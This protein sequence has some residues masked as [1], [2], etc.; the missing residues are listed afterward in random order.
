MASLQKL[1]TIL[2]EVQEAC[3]QLGLQA[4]TGVFDSTDETAQL[5]GSIAN[6]AGIMV[7]DAYNWEALQESWSITGDGLRT[8]WD[9]PEDMGYIIDN[10]GWA[11]FIRRPV[12]VLNA[13]QWAAISS[14]LSQSFY[15]NPACRIYRNKLQF[16]SPPP[17]N[18][19][20]VFQYRSKNWVLDGDDLSKTL[21]K[22]VKNSD[23][24]RFDWLLMVLAIKVKWLEQKQMNTVAA[25]SDFNDR[26]QQL[27]QKDLVAPVLTLSGP[28]PGG[29]RYLDNFYNTPDTNIGF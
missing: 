14:W 7:G 12:V 3:K 9:L 18:G 28:I 20:I 24:P 17:E 19:E 25:Q 15:I 4:P 26:I 11:N 10:T 22:C 27:T 29:F 16:M 8:E 21:D 23:V 2:Y 1:N 5:M 6:L 13:Q